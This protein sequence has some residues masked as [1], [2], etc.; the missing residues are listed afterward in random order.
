MLNIKKLYERI[1]EIDKELELEYKDGETCWAANLEVERERTEEIICLLEENEIENIEKIIVSNIKWNTDGE[2]VDLPK[3]V[4]INVTIDIDVIS[5]WVICF[6][7]L[8]FITIYIWYLRNDCGLNF[9]NQ[10]E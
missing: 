7:I 4:I 2:N 8:F 1:E 10:N 9:S 5:I 6:F 3:K